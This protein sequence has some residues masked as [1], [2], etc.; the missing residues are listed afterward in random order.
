MRRLL[1][2]QPNVSAETL[3]SFCYNS[4]GRRKPLSPMF[5]TGRK[6]PMRAAPSS[7]IC[8][9]IISKTARLAELLRL[10][11]Q[12]AKLFIAL[13]P[14]RARWPLFCSRLLWAIGCNDVTRHDAVVSVRAGFNGKEISA[15][16]PDKTQL[17]VDGTIRRCVQP[18]LH[19]AANRTENVCAKPISIVGGGLAGLTLGIGLRQQRRPGDDPRGGQLSTP[20]RLRRIYQRTRPG[21]AR[22]PRSAEI[23]RTGRCRPARRPLHF[24]R[25][26]DQLRRTGCRRQ[27]SAFHVSRWIMCWRKNSVN[28][29]ANCKLAFARLSLE[30]TLQR[31]PTVP[32]E[33]GLNS[34]SKASS[35]P[36][37]AVRK[38]N[39]D[40]ARWFGL[41]IHAR[42]VTLA[43]DLEM[44]VSAHG[45]VGLCNLNGGE[46]NICGLFRKRADENGEAKTW[47]DLLRGQPGSPLRERLAGAE[48]DENSF[49]AVAGLSLR[50]QQAARRAPRFASATPSP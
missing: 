37:V 34:N 46:V 48:F 47:R 20:P 41:K 43:A 22:T 49:C 5:S 39:P 11:S 32:P 25:R 42:N 50:P 13:E 40:G 44:H 35:A 17:A 45:Y 14:R 2:L 4:A 19:R 9:C 29:V 24:S 33:T 8:F 26:P 10:I 28:W 31:V 38:Q 21:H 30:F 12:R 6:V 16:W 1:D 36:P 3:A 15:L 27:P 7:P 18:S 23:A